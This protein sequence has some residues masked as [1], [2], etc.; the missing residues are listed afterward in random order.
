[1]YGHSIHKI[2][3]NASFYRCVSIAALFYRFRRR[4]ISIPR[5]RSADSRVRIR[6][7]RRKH[8]SPRHNGRRL[9]KCAVRECVTR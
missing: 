4:T 2:T 9:S 8:E 5:A 6:R 7:P 3:H 1:M